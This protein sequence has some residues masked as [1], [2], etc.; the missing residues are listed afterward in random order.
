MV[1]LAR[2]RPQ[3]RPPA[4]ILREAERLVRNG[5]PELALTGINIGAYNH[6]GLDLAGL[7]VRLAETP[8]L[9]RLRL[10]SIEPQEVTPA[11]ISALRGHG[12][13]C[14]HLHLPLQSGDD[15]VLA[16]MRRRYRAEEFLETVERIKSSLDN[17]AISTDVI[18]GFPGEDERAFENTYATCQKAGF[19]RLHVF[20]FSPR[21]GTPAAVMKHTAHD[22]EIEQWKNRLLV[23]ADSEAER[24][25]RSCVGLLERAIGETGPALTDRYL[26][27]YIKDRV[28][29]P[30][31]SAIVRI[32]GSTGPDL[33][34][35]SVTQ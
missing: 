29:A 27:V 26:R 12:K 5:H 21:P 32:T 8:G 17:P 30:G 6:D 23:L 34:G 9:A 24:Y 10:G 19:A 15:G 2:G 35:E 1:P 25:A 14:S 31:E 7:I 33:E 4:D 11:L 16:A 22:H 3:S 20:L 28:L 13:I 18:V